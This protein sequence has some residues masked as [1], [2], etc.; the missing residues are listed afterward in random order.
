MTIVAAA[1][2]GGRTPVTAIQA[3][4]A[5]TKRADPSIDEEVRSGFEFCLFRDL[6]SPGGDCAIAVRVDER[7]LRLGSL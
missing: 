4:S 5:G 2:G 6:S 3:V 1:R 7:A